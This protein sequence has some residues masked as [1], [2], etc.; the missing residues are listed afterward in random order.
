MEGVVEGGGVWGS[1]MRVVMEWGEWSVI[2]L[3]V[4]FEL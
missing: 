2:D 3:R 4:K 1:R